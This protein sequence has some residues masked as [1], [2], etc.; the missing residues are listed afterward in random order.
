MAYVPGSR[1]SINTSHGEGGEE[2]KKG[3]ESPPYT[4]EQITFRYPKGPLL[5]PVVLGWI[6]NG[7]LKLTSCCGLP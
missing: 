4:N 6:I 1:C 5:L 3:T 7:G 2:G